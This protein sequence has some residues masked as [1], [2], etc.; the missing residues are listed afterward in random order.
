MKKSFFLNKTLI[1]LIR[2]IKLI[3]IKDCNFV[4]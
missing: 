3:N 4:F 1:V 2:L